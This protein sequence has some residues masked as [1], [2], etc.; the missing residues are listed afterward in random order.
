M[1]V[2]GFKLTAWRFM[3]LSAATAVLVAACG[4]SGGT[5]TSVTPTVGPTTGAGATTA[6]SGLTIATG[7]TASAGTVLTGQ[8]GLTLYTY[9][10]DTVPNSSTCTASCATN[11]PAVTVDDGQTPVAG[12]GVTGT[13]ATFIRADDSKTQVSYNGAALYYFG[14]DSASGDANGQGKGGV[15]FAATPSGSAGG[16]PAPSAGE[17]PEASNDGSTLTVNLAAGSAGSYLTG[18]AGKALYFYKKD[19]QSDSACTSSKCTS[20]W[21][22]LTLSKGQKATAGDGVTGTVATFARADGKKQV[23]VNGQPLYY[24]AGDNA[25][26]DTNG[27]GVS[28]DW[29][30]AIPKSKGR[31]GY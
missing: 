20:S 26:G 13:V 10:K 27:V 19:S 11:W 5:P 31:P 4:G 2:F 6:S 28:P 16:S 18:D 23:T 9:T 30:L 1:G 24:F 22:P 17:T 8:G 14:G 7:M 12:T 15:W 25:S 3:G 29:S 21:P